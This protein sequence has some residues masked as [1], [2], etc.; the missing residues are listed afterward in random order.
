[1]RYEKRYDYLVAYNFNAEGY[2]TPCSGTMQ[3]R[4]KKKIKTLEDINELNDFIKQNVDGVINLN[5]YNYIFVG[6]SRMK[7]DTENEQK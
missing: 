2:L 7:I 3:I 4:R 1:M 5:V 6:T